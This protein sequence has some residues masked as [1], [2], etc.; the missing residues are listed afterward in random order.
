MSRGSEGR[1]ESRYDV[2][3]PTTRWMSSRM[4]EESGWSWREAMEKGR[5]RRG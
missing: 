2:P 1:R 4:V 3:G 5:R